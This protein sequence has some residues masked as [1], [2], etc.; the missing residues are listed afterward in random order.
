[1]VAA[2]FSHLHSIARDFSPSRFPYARFAA[3]LAIGTA[4]AWL[5]TRWNLPLPWMLGAMTAC[6]LAALLRAPMA[7]P[8]TVRPLMTVV[9]GVMLGSGFSPDVVESVPRW[10]PTI[11]GLAAFVLVAGVASVAY[12][13]KVAGFDL[14]TAYFAGMPGGLIEMVVLGEER[15]GDA[16]TI[17]LV[18]SARIL[19][20]VLAL[21]FV[22]QVIIGVPLGA[23]ARFGTSVLAT[24]WWDEAWFVL[25]AATGVLIGRALRL[26]AWLLV[27]PMLASAVVHVTGLSRFV[28]PIEI[29]NLAQLVLGTSI[30]CRF[31][32]SA[33]RE[34]FRILLMT[35][36]STTILLG[37]TLAFAVGISRVS[38]YDVMPLV[39]AYS[40]GGL[41]EMSLVALALHSEVAFVAAHHI[42]RVVF[43]MAAA[44][45][46]FA[47]LQRK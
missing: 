34:I 33:S 12:F 10:L 4:G 1:M 13:R 6:T 38:A 44:G 29:V 46:V 40:P 24:T 47:F 16:R 19:L 25:T 3:A 32:G 5:F 27:G 45:P 22:I 41:A 17:A 30:G 42:L 2:L 36:G 23:R 21:P 26:P 20:V 28:P 8:A 43:V 14:T 35:L 37:L 15:G 31:A 39:M 18:H 9:I 7:A 11:L